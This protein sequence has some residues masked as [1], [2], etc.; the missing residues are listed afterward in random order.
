[1]RR[2]P[3]VCVGTPAGGR[4]R[5]G[6]TSRS[7]GGSGGGRSP[8]GRLSRALGRCAGGGGPRG[9]RQ[10]GVKPGMARSRALR[11]ARDPASRL[12]ARRVTRAGVAGSE[13]RGRRGSKRGLWGAGQPA[14][15]R[16]GGAGTWPGPPLVGGRGWGAQAY[17]RPAGACPASHRWG[18]G[19]VAGCRR[20][21]RSGPAGEACR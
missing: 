18:L 9:L 1:M 2:R 12:G 10:G 11:Q 20:R 14:V 15:L 7:T 19:L 16:P 8:C 6:R 5:R 17:P 21:A 4:A 13:G 3:A